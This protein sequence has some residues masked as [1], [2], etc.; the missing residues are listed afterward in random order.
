LKEVRVRVLFP[1]LLLA[2]CSQGGAV[3]RVRSTFD[4]APL[5]DP[6]PRPADSCHTEM[7]QGYEGRT[8]AALD[9]I[10]FAQPVRIIGPGDAVT[11]DY[12]PVRINF[13]LDHTGTITRIWC[14]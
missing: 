6:Q 4:G 3:D 8:G 14:G 11:E 10:V 2:A 12:S 9:G 5:P 7:F 13:D 1:I